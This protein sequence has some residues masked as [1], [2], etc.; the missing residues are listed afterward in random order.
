MASSICW[1]P[2]AGGFQVLGCVALYVGSTALARLDLVTEIAEPIGQFGLINGGRKLLTIEVTLRLKCA[3]RTVGS[4]CHIED[5][6]MGMKLGSGV[7]VNWASGVMLKLGNDELGSRFGGIVTAE[8]SLSVPFQLC[9][10]D[11][12][13]LPVGFA[14]TIIASYQSGQRDGLWGGKCRVPS[15]PMLHWLHGRSV[16]SRV[17][18]AFAML[19]QLLCGMGILPFTQA[20][21]MLCVNGSDKAVFSSQLPLPFSKNR[22]ALLPV[23]LFG[24][25]ELL[26]VVRLRLAGANWLRDGEHSLWPFVG[27]SMRNN[28]GVKYGQFTANNDATKA[29]WARE[30]IDGVGAASYIPDTIRAAEIGTAIDELLTAHRGFNNFHIEPSFARRLESL[31]GDKGLIPSPI[32][33]SYVEGLVE[34]FLT[35]GHGVAWSAEPTYQQLLSKLDASQA[36]LA[37]LSFRKIHISSQLQFG[38]GTQKYKELVVLAKTKVAS[39]QGIDILSIIETYKPPLVN[40]RSETKLMEKVSAITKSLGF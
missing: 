21:K 8:T 9:E 32:A 14:D 23:V 37:V 5:D 10:S 26:G 1:R 11:G 40:M 16:W 17:L 3:S 18:L 27:E 15:R 12:H 33:E 24:R 38:L 20:S 25:R 30:F 39:P 28:L 2:G 7:A 13:G 29:K 22:I 6:G 4:L 19:D 35:N 31:V 36:L 34:V